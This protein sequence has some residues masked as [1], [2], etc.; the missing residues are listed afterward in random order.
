M[1]LFDLELI[2]QVAEEQRKDLLR[3]AEQAKL[4][5]LVKRNQ[6]NH[7]SRRLGWFLARVGRLLVR[8][9]RRLEQS[10]TAPPLPAQWPNAYRKD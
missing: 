7:S 10:D 4:V 6:G 5:R 2:R 1:S 9:G 8:L 3:K